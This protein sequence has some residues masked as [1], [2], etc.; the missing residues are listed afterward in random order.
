MDGFIERFTFKVIQKHLFFLP[1]YIFLSSYY[2]HVLF[3]WQEMK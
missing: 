1:T 3:F 2:R